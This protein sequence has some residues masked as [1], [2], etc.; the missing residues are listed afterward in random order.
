MIIL[1]KTDLLRDKE[2]QILS[3]LTS[4]IVG[5]NGHATVLTCEFGDVP[6]DKVCLHSTAYSLTHSPTHSP[7]HSLTHFLT[8]P[9]TRP[10]THS[11]THSRTHSLTHLLTHPPTRPLTYSLAYFVITQLLNLKAFD[12]LRNHI[13]VTPAN[14]TPAT[15]DENGATTKKMFMN[16]DSNGYPALTISFTHLLTHSLTH[17]LTHLLTHSLTYSLTHLLNHSIFNH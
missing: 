1:N 2:E 16:I 3:T 12:P 6:I 13:N 7:T 10:L 4:N 15:R 17:S 8:H 14:V 11:L 9:L 5:I